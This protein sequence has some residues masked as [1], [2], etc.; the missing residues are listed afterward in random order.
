MAVLGDTQL[1]DLATALRAGSQAK[2]DL[3][4]LDA[5]YADTKAK[6]NRAYMADR[7]GNLMNW[8]DLLTDVTGQYR[9]DQ[10]L[11]AITQQRDAARGVVAANENALPMYNA[12]LAQAKVKRDAVISDRNYTAAN[13]RDALTQAKEVTR[14]AEKVATEQVRVDEEAA[15]LE[16]AGLVGS[17]Q[18]MYSKE[19][20]EPTEVYDRIVGYLR[21][22]ESWNDGKRLGESPYKKRVNK[23][24]QFV[25]V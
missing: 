2:A 8:G 21:P 17:L 20:G 11:P 15:E 16:R 18:P 5:N 12:G 1:N 4:G 10:D 24:M 7:S 6:G 19:S 14:K 13:K 22:I 9:S 25:D 3:L 23:N